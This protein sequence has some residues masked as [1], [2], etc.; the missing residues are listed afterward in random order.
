MKRMPCVPYTANEHTEKEKI[1]TKT[2]YA[3]S[4]WSCFEAWHHVG[5]NIL[6]DARAMHAKFGRQCM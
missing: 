1:V 5:N 2:N 6:A 4:D 3:Q